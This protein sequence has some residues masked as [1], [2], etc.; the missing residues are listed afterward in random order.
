MVE[1]ND[2][3]RDFISF[4]FGK[5]FQVMMAKNGNAGFKKAIKIIPDIII[6]DIKM[7]GKDG[8]AL[9]A[10]LKTDERTSHIPIILLTASSREQNELKSLKAGADDYVTKPFKITILEKR[11]NNLIRSRKLLRQRY[12]QEGFLKPKDIAITPTD[13]LFL[14]KVQKVMDEHLAETDFNAAKFSTLVGM[15]RMQLH[16]KLMLYSGLSTSA[17]IRSQRLK[18]AVQILKT[19]DATIN[20][21]AYAVGFNTPS[22]FIKCFKETYKKTPLEYLQKPK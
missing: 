9:C 13:E 1:D 14:D 10:D 22:Y 18:Q 19:S 5:T 16:R 15:S 6:S 2:D 17:F 4:E 12:R 11:V 3:V 8:I 20:E 7:P 21:V